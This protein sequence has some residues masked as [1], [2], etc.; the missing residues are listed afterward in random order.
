MNIVITHATPRVRP[1]HPTV[2]HVERFRT[3]NRHVPRRS[4]PS[5]AVPV[6]AVP[7]RPQPSPA[8]PSHPQ[9]P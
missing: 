5:P 3:L 1:Q 9:Q 8:V 6:I 7:S 2:S 4:P